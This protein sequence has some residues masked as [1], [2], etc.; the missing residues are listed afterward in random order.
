MDIKMAH[1]ALGHLEV[2]KKKELVLAL[3]TMTQE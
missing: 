3:L 1:M 2:P